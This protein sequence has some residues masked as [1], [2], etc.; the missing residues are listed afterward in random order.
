MRP[1]SAII[2]PARLAAAPYVARRPIRNHSPAIHPELDAEARLAVLD[3]IFPDVEPAPIFPDAE[4]VPIIRDAEPSPIIRDAEPAP[5]IPDLRS[6]DAASHADNDHA[7]QDSGSGAPET[8]PTTT[9]HADT[10][11]LMR[12][13][14]ELALPADQMER[15]REVAQLPEPD[16]L[17][18]VFMYMN[19]IRTK[20][21]QK[22]L[23]PHLEAYGR[24]HTVASR[25]L[26]PRT[27][28]VLIKE[29]VD[30]MDNDWKATYLPAGYANQ[31]DTAVNSVSLLIRELLKYEKSGLAKLIMVGARQGGRGTGVAI[32][33]ITDIVVSVL[34]EYSP[35]HALMSR[36]EVAASINV[37]LVVRMA[38]LR[39]HMYIQHQQDRT[40]TLVRS[41]WE[42][43]D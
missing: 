28:L 18:G 27:P 10:M 39:L 13:A 42:Q 26:I 15:F 31:E 40:T 43:I 8:E 29:E 32:P 21:R 11:T 7:D 33:Q 41:P 36:A 37:S 19:F 2:S 5:I 23:L 35:R 14:E 6:D 16:R 1:A 4:P 38:Y 20:A 17:M 22:L 25:A 9:S 24:T 34:R 3:P 30:A 12:L